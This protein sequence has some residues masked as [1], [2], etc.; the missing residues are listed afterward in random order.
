VKVPPSARAPTSPALITPYSTHALPSSA[1][2]L[3]S[4]TAVDE[5]YTWKAGFR[6]AHFLKKII[7]YC[8]AAVLEDGLQMLPATSSNAF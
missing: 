3:A 4:T 8:V 7:C 6:P 2:A 5:N 1:Q